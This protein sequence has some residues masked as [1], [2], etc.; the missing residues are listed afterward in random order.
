M[1][2]LS[3]PG[4]E[5]A[6]DEVF[7]LAEMMCYESSYEDIREEMLEWLKEVRREVTVRPAEKIRRKCTLCRELGHNRL[8]CK[9]KPRLRVAP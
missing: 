9:K 7:D 3:K 1:T 6:L 4:T 5:E 8:T 2:L